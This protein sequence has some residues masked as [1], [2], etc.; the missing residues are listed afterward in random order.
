MEEKLVEFKNIIVNKLRTEKSM[1]FVEITEYMT[2]FGFSEWET[3]T[4]LPTLCKAGFL[5][6]V[7]RT[8]KKKKFFVTTEEKETRYYLK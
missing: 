6:K 8:I 7:T 2:G 5:Q 4:S 1:T 3:A